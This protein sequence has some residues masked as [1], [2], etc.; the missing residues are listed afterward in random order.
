MEAAQAIVSFFVEGVVV[1]LFVSVAC[2]VFL[3]VVDL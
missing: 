1:A 3:S 2:S